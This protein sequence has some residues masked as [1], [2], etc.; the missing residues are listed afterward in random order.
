[1]TKAFAVASLAV[2]TLGLLIGIGFAVVGEV[3]GNNDLPLENRQLLT[4]IQSLTSERDS[5]LESVK[6]ERG[7]G[8]QYL[9]VLGLQNK[10]LFESKSTPPKVTPLG[11]WPRE[12]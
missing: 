2:W 3:N 9:G 4:E 7:R 1:M 12:E 11:P 10:M 8:D 6:S 5:L